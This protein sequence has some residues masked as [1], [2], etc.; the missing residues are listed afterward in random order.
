M[1]DVF[2]KGI[3]QDIAHVL[4]N[5]DAR[6]LEQKQLLQKTKSHQSLVSAKLNIPG[7]IKNNFY[8]TDF[9]QHGLTEFLKNL[10]VDYQLLWDVAT[11]P[12]VFLI[13]NGDT[14][15][16]KQAA[17][18]FEDNNELGRLF[19]IDVL[20]VENGAIHPL[21]RHDFDQPERKCLLCDKPAKVCARSRTHSVAEMQKYINKLINK[22]LE[23]SWN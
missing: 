18:K 17:I 15:D 8:L 13:I 1:I 9:F 2:S 7:P 11:G 6:V 20:K 4:N 14:S 10:A 16:I 3:P 22:Q 19:D 23:F 21:S 5:R 12:E